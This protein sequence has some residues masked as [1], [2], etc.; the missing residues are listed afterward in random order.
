MAAVRLKVGRVTETRS[1]GPN[2]KYL[3]FLLKRFGQKYKPLTA[4]KRKH[5][6]CLVWSPFTNQRGYSG[7]C[8][9]RKK[10]VK[11]QGQRI[12]VL[13]TL[14]GWL[15]QR[16]VNQRSARKKVEADL[17]TRNVCRVS[18]TE[19]RFWLFH[20]R[21]EE[22]VTRSL[23]Q[24]IVDPDPEHMDIILMLFVWRKP[25][26]MKQ[27]LIMRFFLQ[28]TTSTDAIVLVEL[29]VALRLQSKAHF[30]RFNWKY[31][32]TSQAWRWLLSK[33]IT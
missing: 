3:Q 19:L 26:W 21:V 13:A 8:S 27:L 33:L 12:K 28:L 20:F 32:P 5:R 25:H 22:Y 9:C 11:T 30:L 14:S 2:L 29:A 18:Y 15:V 24:N 16:T 6:K 17:F 1:R 10:T 7:K 23:D 31:R 4:R